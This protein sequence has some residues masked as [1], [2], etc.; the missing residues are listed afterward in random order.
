MRDCPVAYNAVQHHGE[1][2]N[3]NVYEYKTFI[4]IRL[5]KYVT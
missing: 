3:V 1:R 5:D 2:V 4:L